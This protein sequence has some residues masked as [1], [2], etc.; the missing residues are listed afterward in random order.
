MRRRKLRA[1]NCGIAPLAPHSLPMLRFNQIGCRCRC[2]G[3]K[4]RASS[5]HLDSAGNHL[6]ILDTHTY[7]H[8]LDT[9]A[10]STTQSAYY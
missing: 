1:L 8:C 2:Q 5:Q 10:A 7:K 4:L 3:M 6:G 9:T